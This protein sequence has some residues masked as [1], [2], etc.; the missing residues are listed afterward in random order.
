MKDKD[1]L[2]GFKGIGFAALLSLLLIAVGYALIHF[3]D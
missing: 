3:I 2:S 1:N